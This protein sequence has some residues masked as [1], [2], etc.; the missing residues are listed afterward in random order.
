MYCF[1]SSVDAPLV[2]AQGDV[3]H[4][5]HLAES[6]RQDL[7]STSLVRHVENELDETRLG[8]CHEMLR[9]ATKGFVGKIL[10]RRGGRCIVFS[11]FFGAQVALVRL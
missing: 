1:Y 5:G 11:G 8:C 2:D 4:V 9:V 10:K 7:F 3:P 6:S